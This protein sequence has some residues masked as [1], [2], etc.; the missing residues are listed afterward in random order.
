MSCGKSEAGH[1]I[2]GL[3]GAEIKYS[4]PD[5]DPGIG[6]NEMKKKYTLYVK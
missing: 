2:V 6:G 4:Q 3:R 1:V 5:I